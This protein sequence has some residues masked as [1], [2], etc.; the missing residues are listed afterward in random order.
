M[1][2]RPCVQ[3]CAHC[4]CMVASAST[5]TFTHYVCCKCGDRRAFRP[6]VGWGYPY[7][8]DTYPTPN[9]ITARC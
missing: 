2:N 5:A 1:C 9:Q 6:A 4:Y 8:G 3:H 7:Y